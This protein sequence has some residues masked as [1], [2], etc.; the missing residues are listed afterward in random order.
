MM[1][2]SAGATRSFSLIVNIPEFPPY[3]ERDNDFI[4][5]RK[6]QRG[7]YGMPSSST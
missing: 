7:K 2:T 5:V 3:I 4:C 6:K 1:M